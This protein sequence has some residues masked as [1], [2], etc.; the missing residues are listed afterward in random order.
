M[1][2]QAMEEGNK[3]EHYRI[4][5]DKGQSNLRIDKFLV[6][7]INNTSRT[8]IQ[9][10]AEA[11]NILVNGREVKANYKVKAGDDVA[12]VLDYPP[13]E[14]ELVPENIPLDIVYEDD[15]LV[16]VNKPAGLVV[17]PSY[18]HYTGTLVNALAYHL[19]D[20]VLF[21]GEDIRPGLVHRLDKNTSGLLVVAKNEQAKAHLANQF[22]YKTAR[23]KYQALV[24][25]RF[26]EE[27]GTITGNLGRHPKNRKVMTVFP[28]GEQGK[29]AV[30]H[31]SV[32]ES[33][34]Y[35]TFVE[36][37]L[38]TGRTHQIRIHMKYAGHPV[39][40]DEEYG[41]NKILKGTT[42]TKYKQFVENCFK[43]IPRQALHAKSL[44]F[45]HPVTGEQMHFES[46]LPNDMQE[47]LE[48]WRQY[49]RY[50]K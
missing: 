38:E 48:K 10:A 47:V 27:E 23:R 33:F 14:I 7:R 3:Y 26:D 45:V 30:T 6:D 25:G 46:E 37:R 17:H 13:R 49:I 34:D 20:N 29:N 24:W 35:V 15:T 42:F 11:G 50:R 8:K 5:A 39:F 43:V 1:T 31:Y 44:G 36:C 22:F 28:E 18:G 19:Q 2:Q 12:V 16:V 9:Q 4:V 21:K 40:N 41:G 32:L